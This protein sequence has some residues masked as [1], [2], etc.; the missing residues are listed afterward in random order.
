MYLDDGFHLKVIDDDFEDTVSFYKLSKN[1]A[2]KIEEVKDF[3]PITVSSSKTSKFKLVVERNAV[4][5]MNGDK[6]HTKI[7]C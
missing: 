2:Q 6:I 1:D 3:K 7:N 4:R 5:V